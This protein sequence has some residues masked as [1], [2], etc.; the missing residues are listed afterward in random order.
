MIE[1]LTQGE[2]VNRRC[3]SV[4][5]IEAVVE[6]LGPLI[7]PLLIELRDVHRRSK[8]LSEQL[9]IAD[10]RVSTAK[11][12]GHMEAAALQHQIAANAVHAL[13]GRLLEAEVD[14]ELRKAGFEYP[15]GIGGVK[16][17]MG[18]LKRYRANA[19]AFEDFL[20]RI[21]DIEGR[22]NEDGP[23]EP[24]DHRDAMQRLDQIRTVIKEFDDYER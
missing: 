12:D 4:E 3:L 23:G 1:T 18:F 14:Q 2:G 22:E 7:R 8:H 15:R 19:N 10:L 11:A 21:A 6:D 9:Q 16:D 20:S 5:D 24:I 17:A 13:R